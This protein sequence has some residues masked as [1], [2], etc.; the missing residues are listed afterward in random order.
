MELEDWRFIRGNCSLINVI[1]AQS[2]HGLESLEQSEP[3]MLG[4][5]EIDYI[6]YQI[7]RRRTRPFQRRIPLTDKDNAPRLAAPIYTTHP[8][9]QSWDTAKCN[10]TFRRC[11]VDLE[12]CTLI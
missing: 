9:S 5:C 3:A 4:T 1:V 12:G 6:A 11:G 7:V 10:Q 8:T 2:C